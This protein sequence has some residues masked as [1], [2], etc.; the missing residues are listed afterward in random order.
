MK[1]VWL[2]SLLATC[3]GFVVAT[4]YLSDP[5]SAFAANGSASCGAREDATCSAHTCVCEDGVGCTGFDENLN[6]VSNSS[7]A[8][9]PLKKAPT[10]PFRPF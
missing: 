9:Q 7:C 1:R 4:S 2:A 6:V 8:D 3:L 10:T 5:P